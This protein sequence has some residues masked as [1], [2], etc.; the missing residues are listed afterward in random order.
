MR[1]TT[2]R[3][4]GTD[5]SIWGGEVLVGDLMRIRALR[6]APPGAH[7][8]RRRRDPRAV[9]H[10]LL[11]AR[12]ACGEPRAAGCAR[13]RRSTRPLAP[14]RRHRAERGGLA[15]DDEHG[16]SLRR[17]RGVMRGPRRVSYEGQ[18]AVE[19]EGRRAAGGGLRDAADRGER[20]PRDRSAGRDPAIA[21]DAARGVPLPRRVAISRGRRR[22][23]RRGRALC[24]R[25]RGL[26]VVVLSGGVF[27]N[28]RL[29]ER[30]AALLTAAG[31][32]RSCRSGFRRMTAASPTVRPQWRRR[33]TAPER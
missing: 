14:G 10:G 18:A 1:S 24:G 7:A 31:L 30:T 32:H 4:Y 33:A 12:S 3:G 21:G 15:G 2:G 5:G 16:P 29:L 27:Q 28:R 22:S 6:G 13:G 17:G 25:A 9:A 11:V 8:G 26:E 23:R 19:L 20:A